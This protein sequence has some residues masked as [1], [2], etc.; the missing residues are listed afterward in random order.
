[1]QARD[2]FG[3]MEKISVNEA[4]LIQLDPGMGYTAG[5][6]YTMLP[7]VAEQ[8]RIEPGKWFFF[9]F[10]YTEHTQVTPG[11]P[12]LQAYLLTYIHTYFG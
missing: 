5:E 10:F 8:Y 3:C 6:Y 2:E 7:L 4:D 1:M 12:M 9:F 11:L